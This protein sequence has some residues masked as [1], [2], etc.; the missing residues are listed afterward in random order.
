MTSSHVP[1]LWIC[2]HDI[3]DG[4]ARKSC[5]SGTCTHFAPLSDHLQH[6]FSGVY[7]QITFDIPMSWSSNISCLVAYQCDSAPTS[8]TAGAALH[9]RQALLRSCVDMYS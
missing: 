9:T 2:T 7:Y 3:L 5:G 4:G 8:M 6:P 1:V